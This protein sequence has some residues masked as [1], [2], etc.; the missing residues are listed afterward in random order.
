[1]QAAWKV[2]GETKKEKVEIVESDK[3]DYELFDRWL[4]FLQKPPV[5]Y[6]DLKAWQDMIKGGGTAA[7]AKRLAMSSRKSSSI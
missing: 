1:M 3:L 2:L 7:A 5:F 6:P 4:R